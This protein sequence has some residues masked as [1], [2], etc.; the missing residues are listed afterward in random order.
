MSSN[1]QFAGPFLKGFAHSN[2]TVTTTPTNWVAI[3]DAGKRR[4]GV[5][6]Q[7]T[8]TSVNVGLILADTGTSGILIAPMSSFTIDNYN[9]PIRMYSAS[10]TVTVHV[11]IATA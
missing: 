3:A 2:Y 1:I 8:S 7:N 5:I 10:G 11:A 9:G 4:A 6:I